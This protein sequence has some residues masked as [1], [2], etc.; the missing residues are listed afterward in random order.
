MSMQHEMEIQISLI[1][2]GNIINSVRFDFVQFVTPSKFV[3]C[4]VKTCCLARIKRFQKWCQSIGFPLRM[5]CWNFFLII[6]QPL[7]VHKNEII[8]RYLISIT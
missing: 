2:F 5:S 3:L 6:F 8:K 7:S 4:H 1:W